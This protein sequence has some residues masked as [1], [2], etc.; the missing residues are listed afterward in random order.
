MTTVNTSPITLL[1]GDDEYLVNRHAREIVGQRQQAD[2]STELETIDGMVTSV[3][4]AE[5]AIRRCQAAL[6][7]PGLFST[8]R[9]VWFKDVTF[10]ADTRAAQSAT[11]QDALGD[12][13]AFLEKGLPDGFTLVITAESID[14]RRA[15]AKSLLKQ[16]RTMEFSRTGKDTTER[17]S[18][19]QGILA[20]HGCEM[21]AP[22][23]QLLC[24]KVGTDTRR[25]V[26]ET[27]KLC[28]YVLPDTRIDARAVET[29]VSHTTETA[30]YELANRFCDFD[31]PGAVQTLH[32]LLFQ[33]HSV[34]G[35]IAHL[36][37][38]IRD[39]LL[40]REALDQGWLQQRGRQLSWQT[41]PPD[42]DQALA[43]LERDPR[44]LPPFI[45]GRLASGAARFT[46]K[47]LDHCLRQIVAAHEKM[48]SSRVPPELILE[49]LLVR[50]LGKARQRVPAT[51]G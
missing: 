32:E 29:I 11:V 16:A 23:L 38:T 14:K 9:V 21:P 30:F 40:F 15:F 3:S 45:A 39:L 26:M 24:E 44:K 35:L 46:R 13:V 33:K 49:I 25:L 50:M 20:Q 43:A 2:P 47:R 48:V 10:L 41:V 7:S 36:E 17:I 4:E 5:S 19:V 51:T 22:L 8:A 27:E 18:I 34:M 31:L 28:L 1:T 37:N 6:Q 42:V 12:L